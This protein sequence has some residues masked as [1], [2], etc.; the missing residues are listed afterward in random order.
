MRRIYIA[1]IL[2]ILFALTFAFVSYDKSKSRDASRNSASRPSRSQGG[3][4]PRLAII[5]DDVGSDPAAVD[6]IFGLT[7]PLTLSVL[8]NHPCSTAVAEEAHR[9]GFQVMLHLPM[10]SQTNE[11]PESEELRVGMST[12]EVARLLGEMVQSVPYAVGV[13]NHQGSLATSDPRLMA[14]LMPLLRARNLFFIDSRTTVATVAYETAERNGVRSGFRNVPFLD[15]IQTEPA[16][17]RQLEI[18]IHDAKKKGEAIVIGHPHPETLRV[19]KEM[20][21]HVQSQA[22]EL[23]YVSTL[24]H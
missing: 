24:V 1:V 11:T 5:I 7:Y 3:H 20:L 16:I 2:C 22:V 14:E 17:R 9:R 4:S 23:V 8:P 13:N 21:P 15:D 12:P 10:E 6:I 19:L 18:A